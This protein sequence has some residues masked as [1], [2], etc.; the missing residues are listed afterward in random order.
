MPRRLH[1]LKQ[2]MNLVFLK[3]NDEP[4]AP[5]E[6]RKIQLEIYHFEYKNNMIL[7]SSKKSL[8]PT[9]EKN[10]EFSCG[11]KEHMQ[12]TTPTPK[13]YGHITISAVEVHRLH[14]FCGKF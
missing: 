10:G 3:K 14:S 2:R 1:Q 6:V 9:I 13:Q 12:R 5:I 8:F 7:N 11:N 4:H